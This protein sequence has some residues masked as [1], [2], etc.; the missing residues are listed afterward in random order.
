VEDAR[1]HLEQERDI[2]IPPNFIKTVQM[3]P[4]RENATRAPGRAA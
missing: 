4:A 2:A 1:K 3:R